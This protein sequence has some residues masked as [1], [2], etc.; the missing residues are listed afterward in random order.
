MGSVI[1]NG[2]LIAENQANISIEDRG[3]KFGDGVF[4]TI[5][6]HDGIPY[7][8]EL[9][10]QRMAG[11]LAAL[12]IG[13][14]TRNLKAFAK[15]LLLENRVNEGILRI[16]VTRGIGSK[17]YLPD[18]ANPASGATY[19]LQTLPLP[20]LPESPV[21]L[22]QASYT[23]PSPKALPVQFKLCQGLNS[24]LA[25]IEAAENECFD[26]VLCNEQ[27]HI[28]ETSSGNIFW[29][30]DKILY[31][32]TLACGVLEGTMRSTV[33]RLSPWRVQETEVTPAQLARADAVFISNAAWKVLAAGELKP[34]GLQWTSAALTE[35]MRALINEDIK[36]YSQQHAKEWQA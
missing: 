18:S 11:G 4:E 22:W 36:T 20:A 19:V 2:Q 12:K 7:Q 14:D 26:A 8:Y 1:I 5:A 30:K 15:Q 25:R 28:C 33:L 34:Q 24:T 9:H 35:E 23:K 16:Q 13:F 17:G 10:M 29:I 6:V 32:P 21:M 3:F 31:T 27:R